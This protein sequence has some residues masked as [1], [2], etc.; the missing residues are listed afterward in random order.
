MDLLDNKEGA[1]GVMKKAFLLELP[2][3]MTD[4]MVSF[5]Q[6]DTYMH[7]INHHCLV[8]V[9]ALALLVCSGTATRA[10]NDTPGAKG[11]TCT[12]TKTSLVKADGMKLVNDSLAV[13]ED[14]NHL[15]FAMWQG[16][17]QAMVLDSVVGEPHDGEI[18]IYASHGRLA[19][20]IKQD[21]AMQVVVDGVASDEY[22]VVSTSVLVPTRSTG[23]ISARKDGHVLVTDAGVVNHW[24]VR[25][26][27]DGYPTDINWVEY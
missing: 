23:P 27:N 25:M 1:A 6:G 19:Y 21:K 7:T 8:L 12:I 5:Y 10:E 14:A 11:P 2:G 20:Y 18:I 26:G 17:S 4:S 24:N 16:K 9:M 13:S 3:R 22:D 15:A